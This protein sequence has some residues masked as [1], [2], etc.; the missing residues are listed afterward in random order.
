[1]TSFSGKKWQVAEKAPR[2]FISK[3]PEFDALTSQLLY[4]R[5][6]DSQKKVDEFFNPD[7]SQDLFDPFLLKDMDR[8]VE[9]IEQAVKKKERVG[10]FGDYDA[11]GVTSS[12]LLMEL[13]RDA[14]GLTGQVY[15]PDRTTE[16][17]GM[18]KKAIDWLADKKVDLIVTCDCGVSNKEEIDYAKKKG[19]DVIVTDHHHVAHKFSRKYIV[20]DSKREGDK[21]PFK[22]LAGVG[23]VFKLIQA[24]VQSKPEILQPGIDERFIKRALDLVTIGT[25]ADC[26]P[27]ISENR[28]LVKY[29]LDILRDTER[30]GLRALFEVA[31]VERDKVD[32]ETVGFFLAPRINAAGRLDHANVA[33]KLFTTKTMAEAQNYA[34]QLQQTNYQRQRVT[35]K[36]FRAARKQIK[37]DVAKNKI[38]LAKG[39]DWPL[40]VVGIVAGRLAD[41]F[42]RPTLVLEEGEEKCVGSG[43]SIEGFNLIEAITSCEDILLEFGGHKMAAGFGLKKDKVD[44]FY[45]RLQKLAEKQ[46]KDV[47]LVSAL[48][49]DGELDIK[50]VDWDLYNSLLRF[51][52]FG[53]DNRQPLFVVPSVYIRDVRA[54]GKQGSHLKMKVGDEKDTISRDVIGFRLGKYAA[55]LNIGDKIDLAG[56]VDCNIWNGTKTLQLKIEDIRK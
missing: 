30:V 21:Y 7:Y 24:V 50:K 26:S 47:D 14:L 37:D 34:E 13:F 5:G 31:G 51:Q 48:V 19:I 20:V 36:I 9:R 43:R 38:L 2:D 11:D 32:T 40:G 1:M 16:G 35:D 55:D 28:T 53:A 46:I 44:E 3:F 6:L 29:G 45:Q 41:E 18:N 8:A 33:F 12:V 42:S 10:I 25:V 17:Y 15:I 49:L 54:I 22:E 27:I 4:S 52:P 23:I 56:Q 39:E